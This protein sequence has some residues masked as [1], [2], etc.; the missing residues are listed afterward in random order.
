M[1]ML[2]ISKQS[3]ISGSQADFKAIQSGR[4]LAKNGYC[5][6]FTAYSVNA[7]GGRG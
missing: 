6:L 4:S 3:T 7:G 1:K 2:I 5:L